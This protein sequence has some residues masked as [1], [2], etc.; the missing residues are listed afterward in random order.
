MIE[1]GNNVLK[2]QENYN[3]IFEKNN[4]LEKEMKKVGLVLRKGVGS[5]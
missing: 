4:S 5:G 1:L 2:L 3:L